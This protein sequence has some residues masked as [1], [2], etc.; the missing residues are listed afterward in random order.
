MDLSTSFSVNVED[1]LP[2]LIIADYTH[3][4]SSHRALAELGLEPDN[5]PDSPGWKVIGRM[6]PLLHRD[7]E[8][9][10]D[11][12]EDDEG[13]KPFVWGVDDSLRGAQ[14]AVMESFD[15]EAAS[16]VKHKIN[17]STEQFQ[18]ALQQES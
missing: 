11:V 17:G 1:L 4:E 7:N 5:E 12:V 13:Y 18:T 2:D 3:V 6:H 16:Y 9:F 14:A 8:E 10:E 15:G